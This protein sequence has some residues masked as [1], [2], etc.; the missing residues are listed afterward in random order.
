MKK[1][2]LL[3]LS[4]WFAGFLAFGQNPQTSTAPLYATN[5]KYV[6]G[7]APGYYPTQQALGALGAQT[8][9]HINVGPGTANCAGTII[10]Y[11]GG[12]FTM[13]A[14]AINYIYLNTASSCA[15][16]VKTTGYTS[17]DIP[18][19]MVT[20]GS[21]TLSSIVDDRT[22]FNVPGTGSSIVTSFN[23]RT[24]AVSLTAADVNGVGAI[25]NSTS[26]NAAT[27]TQLASAPSQCSAGYAPVGVDAAG[28]AQGC[29]AI[30]GGGSGVQYNPTNT[31][32]Y[33]LMS[34]VGADDSRTISSA[35]PAAAWSCNGTT[36]T[37]NTTSAHGLTA[38][39]SWADVSGLTGWFGGNPLGGLQDT[40]FGS[41]KVAS[42]PTSTQ[43]TFAYTLNTGSGSGG[44]I[45]DASYWAVY[46][47]ADGPFF[48]G[49]GTMNYWW[50]PLSS[51]ATNIS[52]F[53]PICTTTCYLLIQAGQNDIF[54]GRTAAQ[55]EGN[56]QTI[57]NVAAS[58]GYNVSQQTLVPT[59]FGITV[60]NTMWTTMQAVNTWLRGQGP[61]Q[62]NIA[63]GH[64]W[65]SLIDAAQYER[66]RQYMIGNQ[67]AASK[68]YAIQI[69]SAFASQSG[70]LLASPQL[71][72][73]GNGVA[74]AGQDMYWIS[75]INPTPT[76]FATVHW[77]ALKNLWTYSQ[78]YGSGG[79]SYPLFMYQWSNAAVGNHICNHWQVNGTTNNDFSY[80]IKYAGSGSTSN[81]LSVAGGAGG[82]TD[83]MKWFANGAIQT[84]HFVSGLI[85]VDS[86]GNWSVASPGLADPGSN[87]VLKRT[88]LNTTAVASFSDI[89]AMW[90]G[91][92][93]TS[94]YLAF[95]GTCSSPSG[96][97]TALNGDANS[98]ATGG[99]TTVVGINNVPLCTGFTPTNGQHLQYTTA[100][101]PNPCYT[102]A[103]PPSG[104]FS[105][106]TGD[107]SSTATGGATTVLGINGVPLCT[108][109]TPTN[110]QNLQYTTASTPNPC[111]TAA[112]AVGGVI[113]PLDNPI[114]AVPGSPNAMDDEWTNETV[115]DPK[116]TSLLYSNGST[117]FLG[118]AYLYLKATAPETGHLSYIYQTAPATPWTVTTKFS[119]HNIMENYRYE[120]LGAEDSSQ[121]LG[122]VRVNYQLATNAGNWQLQSN[123]STCTTG[124]A[125]VNISNSTYPQWAYLYLRLQD[126]GTNIV[127]SH[128]FNGID[129]YQ[130]CVQS[131]T[132]ILASGPT[133]IG[134]SWGNNNSTTSAAMKDDW[135]R[136]TQ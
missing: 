55:I 108:G 38:G 96:T 31:I 46:S 18:V 79:T 62:A 77:D 110:G 52:T 112:T 129:W 67:A 78:N 42:T 94:G 40:G 19:A 109:F 106:L 37:V 116:W 53:L 99:A 22:I 65:N 80:C 125:A 119:M 36:C 98:T 57:W 122:T 27:A 68:N 60:T 90:A 105:A 3:W 63:A 131:R 45:Y 135:F 75:E 93:C 58:K 41:F 95:D 8:G 82:E 64:Y 5:A 111:Y 1:L 21:S 113:K 10:T 71:Y 87:G 20:A 26:G 70:F 88:A 66:D 114:D 9:L 35:V 133:R 15:V 6:N 103:D 115:L 124:S 32:Y 76:G 127:T 97:F 50:S 85:Q 89:V 13:T 34:S 69:N 33:A 81:Y 121:T 91:G 47:V 120:G 92:G 84:P 43:F 24:G 118:S 2:A 51:A 107:A 83:I 25:T 73:Y 128:S 11:A 28:N 123:G 7:V 126:N 102:A 30:G 100:S 117:Q 39:A 74:F 56:L 86:S 17:S 12:T 136:R 72:P 134:L 23:T 48:K 61:T 49:H 130:D 59:N 16:S 14:S 104:T 101:T 132:G 29:A 4:I 44:N 54:S